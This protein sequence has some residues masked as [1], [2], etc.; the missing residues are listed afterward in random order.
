MEGVEKDRL[1]L[2]MELV[3]VNAGATEAFGQ[4]DFNPIGRPITGAF[5]PLGVDIGFHQ[6]DG[7]LIVLL[8]ILTEAFEVEAQEMGGQVRRLTLGREDGKASIAS[9][10]VTRGVALSVGPADPSI[11]WAQM[12]SGAGPAEQGDPSAVLFGD[13]A[14]GLAHHTMLLEV[15]MLSDQFVPA[16][17]FFRAN[18]LHTDFFSNDFSEKQVLC[19]VEGQKGKGF[20]RQTLD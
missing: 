9:H 13:I 17:L 11:P 3:E 20:F 7:M 5:E 4:A 2:V 19:R 16:S 1:G 8:P 12:E 14:E 10:E 18:Q 6:E 15:M